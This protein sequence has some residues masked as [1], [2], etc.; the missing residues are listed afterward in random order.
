MFKDKIIRDMD[1]ANIPN[2]KRYFLFSL[3][4]WVSLDYDNVCLVNSQKVR[5]ILVL[6]INS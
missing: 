4:P 5:T 1:S 2:D 6:N 3:K